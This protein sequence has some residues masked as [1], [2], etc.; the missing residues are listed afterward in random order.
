M[1]L[2]DT[3]VISEIMTTAPSQ[4]V[5]GWLNR[6]EAAAL[7]SQFYTLPVEVNS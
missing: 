3:N 7:S 2:V 5:I 1:I 4:V 6:Q